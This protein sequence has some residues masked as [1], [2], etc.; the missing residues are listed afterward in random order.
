[1]PILINF[2]TLSY[3]VYCYG[4]PLSDEF[5]ASGLPLADMGMICAGPQEMND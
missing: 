3:L 4:A 1:M 5:V 2:F